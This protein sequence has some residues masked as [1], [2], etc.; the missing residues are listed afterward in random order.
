MA[1]EDDGDDYAQMD[2][3]AEADRVEKEIRNDERARIAEL[4]RAE[5]ARTHPTTPQAD[6]LQKILRGC[7]P[8]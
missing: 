2:R 6:V 3:A 1:T 7:Q 5:L 4:I 8:T